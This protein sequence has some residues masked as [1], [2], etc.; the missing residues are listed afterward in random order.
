MSLDKAMQELI[1]NFT[2]A[3][4]TGD[5]NAIEAAALAITKSKSDRHKAE[6]E[7]LRL[8]AE[9][10]SGTRELEAAALLKEVSSLNHLL[11]RLSLVK[12]TGFTFTAK[13]TP[14][15]ADK[16]PQE[17]S[18]IA[19]SVPVVRATRSGGTG[20][21]KT[22]DETGMSLSEVYDLYA[23]EDDKAKM[24]EA[25]AADNK[26]AVEHGLATAKQ[27]NRWRVKNDVKKRVLADGTLTPNK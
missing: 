17:K 26:H 18:S 1:A 22:K 2:K 4:E 15:G 21:G 20:G 3:T 13:G 27:S 5:S 23:T 9:A 25:E 6:A 10:L 19:L 7:S 24:V 11:E 8:E 16:V 14:I 12:A